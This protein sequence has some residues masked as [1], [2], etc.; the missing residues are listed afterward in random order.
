M[1]K[2]QLLPL[3]LLLTMGS[4]RASIVWI[5]GTDA[6]FYT[7]ANWDFSG[8]S[9]L[10][11]NFTAASTISDSLVING[12]TGLSINGT[13][14]LADSVTLSLTN[15]SLSSSGTFGINGTNDV[16]NVFS[17]IVL[18]GTSSL[19]TQFI[20]VGI[21]ASV[22]NGSTLTL[23]GTGDPL[24]SQTEPSQVLLAPGGSISFTTATEYT[25]HVAEIFNSTTGNTLGT[26]PGDF[27]PATGATITAVPEPAAAVLGTLGLLGLLRRR[28]A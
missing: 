26:T 2:Y 28:R 9:V 3:A 23:R 11:A 12:A 6:N 5:G 15:S 1:K 10:P 7:T 16:G 8:S 25:E 4:A 14:T 20:S 18:S 22:G 24:N 21:S 17:N 27:S 19:S 13:L